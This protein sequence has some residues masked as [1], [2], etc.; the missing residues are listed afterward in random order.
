MEDT[1]VYNLETQCNVDGVCLNGLTDACKT[2]NSLIS[3]DV[4]AVQ[5]CSASSKTL[6]SIN[7]NLLDYTLPIDKISLTIFI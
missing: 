4:C 3:I 7:H 6:K 1:V 2:A 5:I